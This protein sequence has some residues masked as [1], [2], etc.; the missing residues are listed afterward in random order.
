MSQGLVNQE[1]QIYKNESQEGM[2]VAA[3]ESEGNC[4]NKGVHCQTRIQ[5][6][7]QK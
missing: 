2:L 7:K 1:K 4:K 6:Q 5:Q 3:G